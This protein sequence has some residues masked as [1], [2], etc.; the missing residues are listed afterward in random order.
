MTVHTQD[1]P[2]AGTVDALR[3]WFESTVTGAE[4]PVRFELLTTGRSCP[5]Y[6]VTDGTGRGWVVRHPPLGHKVETAH[7]VSRE[8][9]VMSALG[10]HTDVP[11]PE[12]VAFCDDRDVVGVP[13]Y[14][15]TFV[16]GTVMFYAEEAAAVPEENRRRAAREL[17]DVLAWIHHVDVDAVGLG[18]LGRRDQY[19]ARQ[20]RRWFGQY[21]ALTPER[22]PLIEELHTALSRSI[23]PQRE[24]TLVH[25]DYA[26][27]NIIAGSDGSLRAVLDWE[28]STLG[29][30]LADL[31]WLLFQWLDRDEKRVYQVSAANQLPGFPD[32]LEL[33][34]WYG[35]ASGRSLDDLP[36][37]YAFAWWKMAC[38][39]VA[40]YRR[41]VDGVRGGEEC[42]PDALWQMVFDLAEGA[43]RA[44]ADGP[45]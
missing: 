8:Y 32:R 35:E 13:F 40:I 10:R 26:F 16:D 14:A 44:L 7:D 36:F 24:T 22:V 12:T 4:P 37:Y 2:A 6:R 23:P 25:G 34:E 15:M 31:G 30:P 19:I 43:R 27:H 3:H 1:G 18:D 41:Y 9:R 33:V 45:R 5:T 11:V 38:A 42:D 39:E 29:D 20:L 17:V 28:L 21:E